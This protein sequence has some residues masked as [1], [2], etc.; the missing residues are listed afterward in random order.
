MDKPKDNTCSDLQEKV[1]LNNLYINHNGFTSKPTP[2]QIIPLFYMF[3]SLL[4]FFS[5]FYTMVLSV[6]FIMTV[7]ISAVIIFLCIVI[8]YFWYRTTS[9]DPTDHVQVLHQEYKR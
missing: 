8:S 6:N 7:L 2:H 5:S 4:S 1:P 9:I 3:L